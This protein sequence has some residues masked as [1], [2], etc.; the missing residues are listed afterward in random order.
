[1]IK[2]Y[3]KVAFRSLAKNKVYTSIN[4]FGLSFG[5][6]CFIFI[7]LWVWDELSYDQFHKGKENIYQVFAERS[8]TGD[9]HVVPYIPSSLVEHISD[10][11][12]EVNEI[13]RVFPAAVVFKNEAYRFTENGI[14]ADASILEIF[15]FPLKEGNASSVF[16]NPNGIVITA[17]LADKYFPNQSALGKQIEIVQQEMQP[18]VITGVLNNIPSNSSLQFDFILSYQEFEDTFRPWWKG[19]NEYSFSNFNVAAYIEAVPGA[20]SGIVSE[21]LTNVLNQYSTVEDDALF[22]YPFS[23]IYLHSDFSEGRQPSGRIKYV[24][25][26][27]VMAAVILLIACINFINLSSVMAGKR[28][29]EAGL[30]KVVG[31]SKRQIAFQFITES[32]LISLASVFF[33]VTAV[34]VLLPMFNVLTGKLITVPFSSGGFLVL[35]LLGGIFIGLLAGTYPAL[36]FSKFELGKKESDGGSGLSTIKKALIVLQFSCS[37]VFIVFTTVVFQQ[38]DYINNKELGL[39]TKNVISHPLYGIR[40]NIDTYKGELLNI[41]GVQSVGFTESDPIGTSNKNNGV[42]WQGKPENTPVYFNIIQASPDFTETFEIKVLEGSP[43]SNSVNQEEVQFIINESAA[44]QI[45]VDNI[46]GQ[47]LTVW[48]NEGRVVG[49]VKDYHH[50]SLMEEIEPLVIICKPEETFNAYI[51]ISGADKSKIIERIGGVYSKFEESYPFDYSFVEDQYQSRYSSVTDA[52]RLSITF[53]IVAILIS[54]LGLF[55][56]SAFVMR[57]KA[58]ETGIRKVMGAGTLNLIYLFSAGFIKLVLVAFVIAVPIAWAYAD[59][60]L[61]GFAYHTQLDYKPFLLAGIVALSI[62]V[63]TVIYNTIKAS[64]ANPV[65]TL[66][67]E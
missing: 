1:M 28:R 54:C 36:Y 56:L 47:N 44:R 62:A 21:K 46:V 31:A 22:T 41:P 12:P 29:L 59:Q 17:E 15:S 67:E 38:V 8:V 18:Y 25:L 26:M 6:A 35:L 14:Y 63:V 49:V 53:S 24:K 32:I 39:E 3:L 33:A 20:N 50:R 37:I 52:G 7:S 60:W 66:K 40:N 5:I 2:N 64:L 57:Q 58:K 4:V 9:S 61:A 43:F 30:R 11:V 16:D 10:Q 27:T 65:N 13:T 51:R 45:M 55:G 42:W 23:K 48:G 34:E 19:N